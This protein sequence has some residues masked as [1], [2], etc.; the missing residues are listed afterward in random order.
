MNGCS[1]R[2]F[3]IAKNSLD[4]LLLHLTT[5]STTP[6]HYRMVMD[7]VMDFVESALMSHRIN[8]SDWDQIYGVV[9]NAKGLP[10]NQWD[11]EAY[12]ETKWR[13]AQAMLMELCGGG[14]VRMLLQF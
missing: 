10:A 2:T 14:K 13:V 1:I 8:K 6:I 7:R 4:A 12:R 9:A 3:V 11:A 5:V